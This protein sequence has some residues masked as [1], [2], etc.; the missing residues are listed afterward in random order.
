MYS[1]CKQFEIMASSRFII[2]K[3]PQKFNM[4]TDV[5]AMNV[6]CEPAPQMQLK[7]LD[8][9]VNQRVSVSVKVV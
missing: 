3:S 6:E 7:E 5:E 1:D 9:A 8:D 4:P 2:E